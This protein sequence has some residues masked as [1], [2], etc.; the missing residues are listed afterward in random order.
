ME[1]SGD[2]LMKLEEKPIKIGDIRKITREH[3]Y[4][5]LIDC[6][7]LIILSMDRFHGKIHWRIW[8]IKFY[9]DDI[10]GMAISN[11]SEKEIRKVS[12]H[13]GTIKDLL[14]R[15]EAPPITGS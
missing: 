7:Y 15:S 8:P 13:F 5:N 9:G 12:D 4:Y 10:K 2:K 3:E 1:K 6:K 11:F 14:N